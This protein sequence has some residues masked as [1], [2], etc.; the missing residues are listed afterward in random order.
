MPSSG[1]VLSGSRLRG[2]GRLES[3]W[4][5]YVIVVPD[6]DDGELPDTSD[7]SIDA[8][9]MTLEEFRTYAAPGTPQTLDAY[10]FA[11]VNV[12]HDRLRGEIGALAAAKE[13]L[14]DPVAERVARHVLD[15]YI[16]SAVRRAK[17][18]RAGQPEAA[19]LHAAESIAWGSRLCSHLEVE[20]D[21]TTGTW[22]GSSTAIHSR[23]H[24]RHQRRQ[25]EGDA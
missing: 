5:R 4:D 6:L 13:F 2:L 16:N 1:V 7:P 12:A 9:I 21:P 17:C 25:P 11:D 14:P 24:G 19:R 18:E 10:A 8:T 23:S 3:D 15:A 22:S 20:C